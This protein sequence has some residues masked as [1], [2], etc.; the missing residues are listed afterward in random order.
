MR[1]ALAALLLPCLAH[2]APVQLAVQGRLLDATGA[3][4]SGGGHTVLVELFAAPTGG[5]P[6][7]DE[8][9]TD[10][11]VAD[12]YFSALLGADP[13]DPLDHTVF[14]TSPL[15]VAF[16][17]DGLAQAPRQRLGAVPSAVSVVGGTVQAARVSVDGGLTL[18]DVGDCAGQADGT[19]GFDGSLVVVCVG[20]APR[21]VGGLV[22]IEDTGSFRRWADGT[23]ATHCDA[24]RS[25][26]AGYAYTGA[27]GSGTY[28]VEP[29]PVGAPGT[30]VNVY[31][32]MATDPD[33]GWQ[34]LLAYAHV[35]G[36]NVARDAGTVPT[37]PTGGYS[38]RYLQPMGYPSASI[39]DEVRLYCHTSAHSRKIHYRTTQAQVRQDAWDGV[40][41]TTVT[42]WQSEV[43]PYANHNAFLPAAA[44]SAYSG[45]SDH[46]TDF[47]FYKGSTYHWGIRGGGTRW[48]CDDFANSA[49]NTTLH[50]VWWR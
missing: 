3:A 14:D 25:P 7:F 35:G 16:T 20:G 30:L 12:G 33:K 43:F 40:G 22:G 9:L 23:F 17:V 50:Q 21:P 6:L 38:H 24:Y 46:F 49:A 41:N 32:D 28:R 45:G 37:N 26:P 27:V 47:S 44:D 36:G 5:S 34:L 18:G 19:L 39:V 8:A 10:V 31:C 48:E 1:H 29:N 42:Q 13:G 2:A 15:Y 11:L 4:V